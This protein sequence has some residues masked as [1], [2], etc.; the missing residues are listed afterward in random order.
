MGPFFYFLSFIRDFGICRCE[1]AKMFKLATLAK[2]KHKICGKYTANMQ[3]RQKQI[4]RHGY[5]FTAKGPLDVGMGSEVSAAH[6]RP[7]VI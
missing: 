1:I 3:R 4:L 2:R 6:P 5:L 7:T